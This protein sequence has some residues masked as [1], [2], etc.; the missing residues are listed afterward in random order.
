[1]HTIA[2]GNPTTITQADGASETILYNDS[3]GIPTHVVDF[4]GNVTTYHARQPR[5]R[6][7]ADR[8]RRPEREFHL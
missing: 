5:Q 4:N 6:H 2:E 7:P 3:F 1:M 8:P